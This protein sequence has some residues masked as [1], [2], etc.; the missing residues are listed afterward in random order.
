MV[1]IKADY[2]LEYLLFSILFLSIQPG[3]YLRMNIS[4]TNEEGLRL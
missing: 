4:M 3:I 1:N 2:L